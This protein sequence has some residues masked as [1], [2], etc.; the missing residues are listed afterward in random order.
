MGLVHLVLCFFIVPPT[1]ADINVAQAE[2]IR[3]AISARSDWAR[4]SSHVTLDHDHDA[5]EALPSTQIDNTTTMTGGVMARADILAVSAVEPQ[6]KTEAQL[7]DVHIG[8]D[9]VGASERIIQQPNS[10]QLPNASNVAS[11][12]VGAPTLNVLDSQLSNFSAPEQTNLQHAAYAG[13]LSGKHIAAATAWLGHVTTSLSRMSSLYIGA[14]PIQFY[15]VTPFITDMV[16]HIVQS[17]AIGLLSS[18]QSQENSNSVLSIVGIA[19]G[20]GALSLA[21]SRTSPPSTLF[22]KHL[23]TVFS[24]IVVLGAGVAVLLADDALE[25]LTLLGI[26]F[27]TLAVVTALSVVTASS[28]IDP[29]SS[30][31]VRILR[32]KSKFSR[33]VFSYLILCTVLILVGAH[34]FRPLLL[35]AF[36]LM[37]HGHL[38]LATLVRYREP[39]N[40]RFEYA[41][42]NLPHFFSTC[43]DVLPAP[44]SEA[45]E[46]V[47]P[48]QV[49]GID[50]PTPPFELA[51]FTDWPACFARV[52][53]E[54]E[55]HADD[56]KLT[57]HKTQWHALLEHLRHSPPFEG[58]DW[59]PL[60]HVMFATIHGEQYR[61]C[62]SLLEGV[63]EQCGVAVGAKS[64]STLPGVLIPKVVA[65]VEDITCVKG[66]SHDPI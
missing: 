16:L 60:A 52:C 18:Q 48:L 41:L 12:Q 5:D 53:E 26:G 33:I 65:L 47:A 29:D 15:C 46:L 8:D 37:L 17:C 61:H 54:V 10:T 35:V 39:L 49:V 14:D 57:K 40:Q 63:L 32:G 19:S 44:D 66:W 21:T 59:K 38:A 34:H 42:E 6:I 64:D 11:E 20:F 28:R 43:D 24:S 55:G 31:I 58:S 22:S 7:H 62:E 13:A 30:S 36:S 51:K 45:S 2:L 27:G 25:S 56:P 9:G 50:Q 1:M 3:R 4:N 23:L